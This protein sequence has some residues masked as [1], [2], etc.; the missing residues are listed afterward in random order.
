MD[1]FSFLITKQLFLYVLRSG[2][3]RKYLVDT[4]ILDPIEVEDDVYI[5]YLIVFRKW[6]LI[7][8]IEE[9]QR[10]IRNHFVAQ[11]KPKKTIW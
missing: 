1:I 10:D 6:L 7:D 11:F 8:D 2:V 4:S 5:K 3:Y 9:N